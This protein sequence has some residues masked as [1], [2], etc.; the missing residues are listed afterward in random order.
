MELLNATKMQAGYTMGMK[1]DGSEMLVVA[2]KGTFLIPQ[3][4]KNAQLAEKQVPLVEAD[5]ATG[6]PGFSAPL[7]ES[8]YAAGKP[9]CDVLL[10]GSAYAPRGRATESVSVT[11]RV[12]ILSKSFEV[13]GDRVWQR[14]R[15]TGPRPFTVMPISYNNA[16]GG[17]DACHPDAK[18]H[19]TYLPNHAGIGFHEKNS[20]NYI[21]GTPLPN[22]QEL[23]R[24]VTQPHGNY[25]P[26]AYGTLG[27]AWE[28]RVKLAGT[29]DQQWLDNKAPFLP[30]DFDELYY[31]AAPADQRIQHPKG[32]EVV[33]LINLTPEG[34]VKFGLPEQTVPVEFFL[35]K[36]DNT[37]VEAVMDT[38]VIE[39]DQQRL[40]VTW[41]ASIPLRKNIFE[42]AQIVV[43]K[44]P[45]G[46]YRARELGK[47]Y[48]GSLGEM[49]KAKFSDV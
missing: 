12:G 3:D 9:E 30:D 38:I 49:V 36:A 23:G 7:Y 11:M 26:M 32:G 34:Y 5:V 41:R 31:Q 48:Y 28:Q 20:T 25:R 35:K 16:F 33:E 6:A 39:P 4:E 42:V 47:N 40:M 27:R 17:T 46:W 15:A 22:T 21:D 44:M 8:D 10:N 18:Y 19:R 45:R 1:P 37:E 43:G 13:V 2:V 14:G 24:P 29:Y